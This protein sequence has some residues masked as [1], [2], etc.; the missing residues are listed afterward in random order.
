MISGTEARF[1][2]FLRDPSQQVHPENS[3]RP[4]AGALQKFGPLPGASVDE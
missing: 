2:V 1:D 3:C 4:G